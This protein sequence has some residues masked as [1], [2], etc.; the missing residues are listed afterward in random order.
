M[1][2]YDEDKFSKDDLIGRFYVP[3][4]KA[5][6]VGGATPPMPE[7]KKL[8]FE[9]EGDVQGEVLASIT[10]VPAGKKGDAPPPDLLP[11]TVDATVE[12][13]VVGLRDMTPVPLIGTLGSALGLGNMGIP[14]ASPY[15]EIDMGDANTRQDTK[16]SSYPSANDPNYLETYSVNM[17]LPK[18]ELFAPTMTLRVRDIRSLPGGYVLGKPLVATGTIALHD[19]LPW[20]KSFKPI[21]FPKG[22]FEV[23]PRP[24][25]LR[26]P[27]HARAPPPLP[28]DPLRRVPSLQG[29]GVAVSSQPP[30]DMCPRRVRSS[31]ALPRTRDAGL[32]RRR[33]RGEDQGDQEGAQEHGRARA[34]RLQADGG[35]DG[36]LPR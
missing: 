29:A 25:P 21:E 16:V 11:A 5:M 32:R 14:L 15:L 35:E 30:T 8:A 34:R 36:R 17:K 9:Y 13:S 20:A 24:V 18:N 6:L 28:P 1:L 31:C 4:T 22:L 23:R 26:A 19:K 27:C 7:W 3:L 10:M 2:V 12:L 33:R